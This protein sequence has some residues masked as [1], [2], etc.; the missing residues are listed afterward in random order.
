MSPDSDVVKELES[1]VQTFVAVAPSS[2]ELLDQCSGLLRRF[3]CTDRFLPLKA[4][5]S[6]GGV[7]PIT[8]VTL[9]ADL[10]SAVNAS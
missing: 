10:P 7:P 3:D 4:F 8:S 2:D 9:L 1:A 6:G 5:L